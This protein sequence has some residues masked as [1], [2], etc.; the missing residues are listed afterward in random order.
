MVNNSLKSNLVLPDEQRYTPLAGNPTDNPKES[1]F[2]TKPS[3]SEIENSAFNLENCLT[4]IND[5]GY[6]QKRTLAILS[7]LWGLVPIIAVLLPFFTIYPIFLCRSTDEYDDTF[8]ICDEESLCD[9]DIE[10]II[11]P[12]TPSRTWINDFDLICENNYLT[13][14]IGSFYFIGMIVSNLTMPTY[15]GKYGRKPVLVFNM[16]LFI[17]NNAFIMIISYN[18]LLIL[19]AFLSGFVYT[20][21][22]IPAFVL[23]FEYITKTSKNTFS[24]ILN[25]SFSIGAILHVIVFYL[26]KSWI[27]SLTF[28]LVIFITLLYFR[29]TILESPTY[30][31][32]KGKT[33]ILIENL[34]TVA[35]LNGTSGNLKKYLEQH[36]TFPKIEVKN[37]NMKSSM[38]DI[39]LYKEYQ[40]KML[41]IGISWFSTSIITYGTL[42]NIK[43]YGSDMLLNAV[44]L[45]SAGIISI[46]SSSQ[47]LNSFG[48]QNTLIFYYSISLASNLLMTIIK[49]P[50]NYL[51]RFL[52]FLSS[53]SI[54]ATGSVN[55]IYTADLFDSR[56]RVSSVS[57][58]S[59]INRVAGTI[60]PIVAAKF[61]LPT[62]WFSVLSGIALFA[63]IRLGKL[64]K[65]V[66]KAEFKL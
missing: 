30:L 66:Q 44:V 11:S 40:F 31:I 53:F 4:V 1:I 12:K 24:S 58:G 65:D 16:I 3:F 49:D 15:C 18:K 23:N 42:F 57:L 17:A 21:I 56:M 51:I 26:F 63:I 41:L 32:E 52:L 38:L 48:C 13:Y 43:Q 28:G 64:L 54:C 59:L 50:G 29:N 55:Y 60:S 61:Y 35:H 6:Y 9:P 2:E 62:M 27:I 34:K 33:D 8:F 20:G 19:Y 45:Y 47:V 39:I 37:E 36:S 25:S 5:N 10:R 14:L 22:A 46:L 7:L